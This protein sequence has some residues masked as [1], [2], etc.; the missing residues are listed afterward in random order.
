MAAFTNSIMAEIPVLNR[1]ASVS[2]DTCILEHIVIDHGSSNFLTIVPFR[3][4]FGS[5]LCV[6]SDL[7]RDWCDPREGERRLAAST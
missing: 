5:Q 4:G 1:I 3:K 6:F 7:N 2:S